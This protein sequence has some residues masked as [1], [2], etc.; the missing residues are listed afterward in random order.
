MTFANEFYQW[1][2]SINANETPNNEIIAFRFGLF[3]TE[4]GIT[5][6]LV[7]SKEFDEEDEDWACNEDFEPKN[8][9]LELPS[10]Y[11]K[12]KK[13]ENVLKD[14][15]IILRAF[16]NSDEFKTSIFKNS[17]AIAAGFDD[18]DLNRIK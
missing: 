4:N 14:A 17:V 9:Y 3:E 18:G 8:K 12:G 16:I 5:M 10:E 13:W 6:Y 1:I 2:R 11:V 7:G 15:L